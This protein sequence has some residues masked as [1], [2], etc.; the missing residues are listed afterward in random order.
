MSHSSGQRPK[1]S[2]SQLSRITLSEL[3]D[4]VV[5]GFVVNRE[6]KRGT[7]TGGGLGQREGYVKVGGE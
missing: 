7:W 4:G 5:D 3:S 1:T 2:N 6:V